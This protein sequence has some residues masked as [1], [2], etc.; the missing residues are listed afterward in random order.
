DHGFWTKH[1]NY[2]QAVRIPIMI[3]APGKTAQGEA[4]GQL[5]ETVDIYP[6][7]A[8]LAGLPAPRVSQPIDGVDLSPVLKNPKMRVRDYAYHAFP[9]GGK[10]GRAFRTERY[11]IVEWSDQNKSPETTVYELYDYERDPLETKNLAK[12][13]P[14]ALKRLKKIMAKEPEAVWQV[15]KKKGKS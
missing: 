11:R 4:T 15:V 8:S 3:A 10:M 14:E 9:K 12:E 13:Q 5:A 1:T 6:T 2:E 7:L